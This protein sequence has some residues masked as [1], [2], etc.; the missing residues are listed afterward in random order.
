[1]QFEWNASAIVGLASTFP[2]L[3]GLSMAMYLFAKTRLKHVAL[4]LLMMLFG[5]AAIVFE[6]LLFG[7]GYYVHELL[8]RHFMLVTAFFTFRFVDNVSRES[9]DPK[10]LASFFLL[11][12]AWV[13][14]NSLATAAL[15]WLPDTAVNRY[16]VAYVVMDVARVLIYAFV[17]FLMCETVLYWTL[18]VYFN[19]PSSL[20]G[21]RTL[22]LAGGVVIGALPFVGLFSEFVVEIPASDL[23]LASTGILL[24][25]VAFLREPKLAFVI[26]FRVLRV[27]AYQTDAG[28]PL[29][30]HSWTDETKTTDEALFS[31]VMQGINLIVAQSLGRGNLREIQLERATLIVRKHAELPV[32]FVLVT[33]KTSR[34]LREALD[35]F[36][37]GF[38][39]QFGQAVRR[40][41]D[42]GA[43]SKA[44]GL[45]TEC[46]P[47][48]PK[49]GEI[50]RAR[51]T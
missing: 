51:P 22:A 38:V 2:M 36:A 47:F 33:T 25:A 35:A 49:Y 32:A 11:A 3:A 40:P 14:F 23:L 46:F 17:L 20:G 50:A 29:F 16:D 28:I 48:V 24:V 30:T 12:G 5:G 15:H 6:T 21:N 1:M 27:M 19:A 10:K 18:K 41:Y 4:L 43:Y 31:G 7:T 9:A 44:E 37:K 39:N 42:D 8:Y 13:A 26:P 34:T 45:V